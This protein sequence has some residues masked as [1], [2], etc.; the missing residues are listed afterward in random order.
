MVVSSHFGG[1]SHGSNGQN[2]SFKEPRY[3][4]G[5]FFSYH[6]ASVQDNLKV[7]GVSFLRVPL[8][9]ES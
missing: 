1:K 2:I 7:Y 3:R 8:F 4:K 5:V 9:G 6:K